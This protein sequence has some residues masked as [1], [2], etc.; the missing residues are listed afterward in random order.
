MRNPVI[1]IASECHCSRNESYTCDDKVV[2]PAIGLKPI[3]AVFAFF[4]VRWT[5]LHPNVPFG[6]H[7]MHSAKFTKGWL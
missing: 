7:A 3:Y 6:V 1:N 5:S 2:K 4:M